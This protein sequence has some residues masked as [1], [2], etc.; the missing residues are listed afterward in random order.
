MSY[1]GLPLVRSTAAFLRSDAFRGPLDAFVERECLVFEQGSDPVGATSRSSRSSQGAGEGFSL[2]LTEIHGEYSALV[3]DLI[4]KHLSSN[5][6]VWQDLESAC[7]GHPDENATRAVRKML[8]PCADFRAFFNMMAECNL[9]LES[10]ALD[11]WHL[12][13]S[14]ASGSDTVDLSKDSLLVM[15]TP[16]PGMSDLV[17]RLGLSERTAGFIAG[18][19]SDGAGGG[20]GA[21]AGLPRPPLELSPVRSHSS[22]KSAT[23]FG[24][25]RD[26]P[27]AEKGPP[28]G[29]G[30]L[31]VKAPPS[32][33]PTAK[34]NSAEV[35]SVESAVQAGPKSAPAASSAPAPRVARPGDPDYDETTTLRLGTS[36]WKIGRQIGRG[37]T[38]RVFLAVDMDVGRTFAVKQ[39]SCGT[40]P[41][42]LAAMTE[43]EQEIK[44]CA[45]AGVGAGQSWRSARL[46]PRLPWRC[47]P[48][49][50]R[51]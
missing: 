15:P 51:R 2:V 11:L 38:A 13:S 10:K 12:Q 23:D 20:A 35:P 48:P 39:M 41:Q 22:R 17:N 37:A 7:E 26:A 42:D 34:S 1:I 21:G 6:A 24:T 28:L 45:C 19:G 30:T 9:E 44:V 16:L 31:G 25:A 33:A 8:E 46:T 3:S 27:R 47:S 43:L 18:G 49:P 36:V 29:A 32:P 40:S 4:E 50:G 14:F 5:G